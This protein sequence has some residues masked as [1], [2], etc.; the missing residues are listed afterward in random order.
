M[1]G[2]STELP[3]IA[4]NGSLSHIGINTGEFI[5]K[6]TRRRCAFSR[7]IERMIEGEGV[8]HVLISVLADEKIILR[9]NRSGTNSILVIQLIS[10][11]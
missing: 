4:G 11:K 10:R 2:T 8:I 6:W 1:S 9:H 3:I 7:G 5:K